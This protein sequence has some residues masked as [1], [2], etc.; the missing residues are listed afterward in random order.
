MKESEKSREQAQVPEETGISS[1]LEEL[2]QDI[3]S[4]KSNFSKD[5][6]E[7]TVLSYSSRSDNT[8][9]LY[10]SEIPKLNIKFSVDR[11]PFPST[12][13][14]PRVVRIPAGKYSENHR[15]AHESFCL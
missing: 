1:G 2:L 15:H 4:R 13:L 12:V 6:P 5:L 11:I 3:R 10:K 14:D 8:Q 9:P 7:G